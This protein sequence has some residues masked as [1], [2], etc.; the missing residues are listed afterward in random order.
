MN[1]SRAD[2]AARPSEARVH[3]TP[4]R[5]TCSESTLY[6]RNAVSSSVIASHLMSFDAN[7]PR[8]AHSCVLPWPPVRPR[9]GRV[10]LAR[11][12]L[13]GEGWPA[14]RRG[15]TRPHAARSRAPR[16]RTITVATCGFSRFALDF[17]PRGGGDWHYAAVVAGG[18]GEGTPQGMPTPRVWVH[19]SCQSNFYSGIFINRKRARKRTCQAQMSPM[20]NA[21]RSPHAPPPMPPWGSRYQCAS[22]SV[23]VPTRQKKKRRAALSHAPTQSPMRLLSLALALA[24][25][26]R[27]YYSHYLARLAV[28]QLHINSANIRNVCNGR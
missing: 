1:R 4:L 10:S 25:V 6:T 18:Q 16:R 14:R 20:A 28:Y 11:G 9:C 7:F 13:G 12:S 17:S 23:H 8:P 3:V 19:P 22:S 26:R 27:V 15:R 24:F 5:G 2:S 21:L